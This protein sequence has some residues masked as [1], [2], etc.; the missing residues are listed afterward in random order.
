MH[1][2]RRS[3]KNTKIGELW[4]RE[5]IR[6]S[7][8]ENKREEG[9][10]GKKKGKDTMSER[11]AHQQAWYRTASS[12]LPPPS[13][14]GHPDDGS[15]WAAA[16]GCSLSTPTLCFSSLFTFSISVVLPGRFCLLRKQALSLSLPPVLGAGQ[17]SK[18]PGPWG[19]QCGE[20]SRLGPWKQRMSNNAAVTRIGFHQRAGHC[21][22]SL[23]PLS[24]PHCLLSTVDSQA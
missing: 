4:F 6:L 11:G 8:L 24:M 17:L 18:L 16:T 7:S 3:A 19:V 15:L 23:Q 12:P 14:S 9:E 20:F 22:C 10:K 2:E 1:L 13:L 5:E 21:L